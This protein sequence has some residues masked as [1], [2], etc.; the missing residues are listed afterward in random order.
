VALAARIDLRESPDES[1]SLELGLREGP[2]RVFRS[3]SSEGL[4]PAPDV[5]L[6]RF[7]KRAEAAIGD[8]GPLAIALIE[9]IE[10]ISDVRELTALLVASSR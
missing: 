8:R 5:L 3:S 2:A 10:S 7:R 1:V 9:H 6:A 4:F